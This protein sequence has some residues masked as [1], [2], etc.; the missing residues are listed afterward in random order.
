MQK[1]GAERAE[2]EEREAYPDLHALD[3]TKPSSQKGNAE[4]GKD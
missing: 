3:Y 1:K 2:H 4:K